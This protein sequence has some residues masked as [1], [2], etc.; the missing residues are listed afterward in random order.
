M[1][2]AQL[3]SMIEAGA[4][5]VVGTV[6][7]D[8]EPRATRAWSAVITRREP[9][10][11]RLAVTADDPV[12]VANLSSGHL[13]LTGADVRTFASVQLKGRVA[14][15]E[16]PTET[17]LDTVRTQTDRLLRAIHETDGNPVEH[18]RRFLPHEVV[19]VELVVDES[20]DQTPGPE[21]G[22][23]LRVR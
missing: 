9:P 2:A 3:E 7:P 8:G 18:L 16:P 20:F 21:A 11:V 6:A 13:S 15:V 4:S 1:F 19:M 5:L 10:H 22:A 12:S 14:S 17:D 23:R